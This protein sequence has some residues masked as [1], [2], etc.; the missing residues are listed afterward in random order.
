MAI[1]QKDVLFTLVKSLSKSEKRQFKLYVGRLG[2]NTEANF[3]SLFNLLD[4]VSAFDD[5]LILKKTKI[6]KQ[7]ISNTKAHLYKQILV[8]LR[9]NPVHQNVRSQI[10]EQFDF[11]AILY[12]KG[13]Y[14]QSLKILDKAKELALT[15]GEN[16]LAYEIVE[17][18]KV[19][20]SQY[21]TRSLSNRADELSMQA[22]EL[23]LK[24]TRTSKLSNLSL[25]LYSLLLKEGYVKNDADS[26]IVK[27]YFEKRLP[28]YKLS[29]L[30][31]REKLFLYQAYLWHSLILQ[32]FVLSYKYSQ[33]WVDLFEEKPQMKKQNPV[34]Y[35]KGVNYLLES[36]Y[37]IKHKT[38][39]NKV[40][41][42]LNF[43]IQNENIA[44]N[45]NT[46]TLTFLYYSQNKLNLYF[47][48]GRFHKGINYTLKLLDQI[49]DYESK[50]DVH[51]I[52][53]FY[54]KIACM[55]F[56]AGKNEECIFYLEKIISNK[57]LKMREDLLCYTRVLN[58]VAHYDA[59]LDYDIDKLIISTYKFLIK[60]NDLHEVQ[61]KMITF[62]KKLST[63]YPQDLHKAFVN[64]H[65]ELSEFENHPYE[66]RS[67]LYLDI[68]SWLESKIQNIPV[69]DIIKQ[70]AKKL[71]K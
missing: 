4:K 29:D 13:L 50:I 21:I 48:E 12:N 37:L 43:D 61:R 3:I 41:E 15:N 56:G 39:F 47:L 63:M 55:Y 54:Y 11:A 9:L 35:L 59:G 64:L 14:K 17:F 19:I 16:N 5:D 26:K 18:E 31:F 58:L 65:K 30:G 40:L 1:E 45:E 2:G 71:I 51:H 42:N 66:K 10:R 68:L 57:D 44:L 34:F 49:K 6:K 22:K 52:M 32:D 28:D 7:Q 70:K 38:K 8:S 62:L 27:L 53:V 25:Q 36:L 33:K 23:S 69:E 24:N 67:F 46:N 60:M 20:E